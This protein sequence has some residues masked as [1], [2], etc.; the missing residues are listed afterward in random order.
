[1]TLRGK[2]VPFER[3]GFSVAGVP[4]SAKGS[5]T[6]AGVERVAEL[7]L[8]G[9]ELE[10]VHGVRIGDELAER[11]GERAAELGVVLTCHG[12]YYINLNSVEI[13]KRRASV[14]RILATARAARKVG[15]R[16]VT[17]H[18]AFYMKQPPRKVFD[19]VRDSLSR[20][21][22][23]LRSEDNH[24]QIRPELTGKPSQFGDL[25]ELLELSSLIDGVFPC[26]DFSHLYA[27]TAG[28]YNTL[29]EFSD[30]L[31]RYAMVLGR[32]A[33]HDLH[34]H[35]SGIEYTPKGE[36]RH[37]ELKE[38]EFNYRDLMRALKKAGARGVVVCESP[39]LED[40]T[41]LLKRSYQ[42]VR[43]EKLQRNYP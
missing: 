18:A 31:E 43:V 42:R 28:G 4:N 37:R 21:V 1:M 16:S 38:S 25:E 30:V 34:L 36:R 32:E 29:E 39:A 35:V 23:T 27:R 22:E 5:G 7:G 17:F 8:D 6:V 2:S 19:V 40:D 10:F 24:V 33:L 11:V 3:L 26:V 12:P 9:M 13:E 41:L 15:A 14:E 20:I